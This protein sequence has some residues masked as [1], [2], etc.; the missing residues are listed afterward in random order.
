MNRRLER[1]IGQR[2][3]EK[4]GHHWALT[5][6]ACEVWGGQAEDAEGAIDRSWSGGE[7]KGES[8]SIA[9]DVQ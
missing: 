3:A 6:F 2:V 5:G 7:L 1:E 4:R 9:R 8:E